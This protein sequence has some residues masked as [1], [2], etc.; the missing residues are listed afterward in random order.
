MRIA[1]AGGAGFVGSHLC[2]RLLADGHEVV[3][4]DNLI[5]GTT[6]SIVEIGLG[7]PLDPQQQPRP[8]LDLAVVIDTSA[9]SLTAQDAMPTLR[10]AV[11]AMLD[12]LEAVDQ[13][14][15]IGA[16]VLWTTA[17]PV[18]GHY[19]A[20]LAGPFFITATIPVFPTPVVT[21]NPK[22]FI[23]AASFAAVC[24]SLNANSGLRCRSM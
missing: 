11:G 14:T 20:D 5:T 23:R 19:W 15:L 16:G 22:A 18:H 13:V 21:S 7:T 9:P 8:A 17:V 3:C 12:G 1:V 6:C 2:R 10:A 24:T 4:V